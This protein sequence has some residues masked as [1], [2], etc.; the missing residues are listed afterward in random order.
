M[1]IT[2]NPSAV[3]K[4]RNSYTILSLVSLLDI[5]E[6]FWSSDMMLALY[7]SGTGSI[8]GSECL[9]LMSLKNEEADV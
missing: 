5:L 2:K 9:L 6:A 8:L 7:L 4:I 1:I 3:R